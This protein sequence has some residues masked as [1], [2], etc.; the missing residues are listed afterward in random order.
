MFSSYH[1]ESSDVD[2]NPIKHVE[3]IESKKQFS[4]DLTNFLKDKEASEKLK[5]E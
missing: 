3:H 1:A 2:E 4:S 5:E